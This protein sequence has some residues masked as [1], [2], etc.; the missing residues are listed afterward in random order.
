MYGIC[1]GVAKAHVVDESSNSEL[2][3]GE[4]NEGEIFGE[5]AAMLGLPRLCRVSARHVFIIYYLFFN[6]EPFVT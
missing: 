6:L 5:V 4:L 3:L 1:R 2:V